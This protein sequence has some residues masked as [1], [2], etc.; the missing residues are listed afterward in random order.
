MY[1]ASYKKACGFFILLGLVGFAFCTFGHICGC[2]HLAHP[3]DGPYPAWYYV[4]DAVWVLSFILASYCLIC[5]RHFIILLFPISL[6][7]VRLVMQTAYLLI[8]I[9]FPCFVALIAV[10]L[11]YLFSKPSPLVEKENTSSEK[12]ICKTAEIIVEN[13]T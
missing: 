13:Q 2:G 9:D 7:V 8:L 10:A 12:D 11:F 1:I 3:E 5:I 4:N 6:I